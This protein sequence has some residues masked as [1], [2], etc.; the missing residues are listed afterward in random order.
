MPPHFYIICSCRNA[1]KWIEKCINSVKDQ[2]IN[3]FTFMLWLDNPSDQ[4]KEIAWQSTRNDARFKLFPAT[5]QVYA[6]KARW[7]L[8]Q[9]ILDA[10]PTDIVVLLDGDDWF[11]S[12]HSLSILAQTYQK[13]KVV[14]TH[15]NFIS[16]NH[17]ICPWSKDYD[18]DV[19]RE[20]KYREAR[21][22]ATHLRT[23]KFGLVNYLNEELFKDPAGNFYKSSTDFA[24]FL[25]IL[26]L[27]GTHSMFIDEVL[28][29]YNH[30]EDQV[31]SEERML[32]QRKNEK[33]IREK[34]K[35]Q[36]LSEEQIHNLISE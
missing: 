35:L 8:L 16:S 10:K 12:P 17:K 31:Y 34:P 15:G 32:E 33:E 4:T 28:Y 36:P 18:V 30:R 25:P 21:W 6:S 3:D 29:V 22:I 20:N 9:S 11:Y 1:E 7:N 5:K 14:A 13:H 23:F 27:A 2:V 24:L 19:K 26:E